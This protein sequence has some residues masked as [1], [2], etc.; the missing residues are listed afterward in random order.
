ML[1]RA[2]EA[3]ATSSRKK[4]AKKT[5]KAPK[6]TAKKKAGKK[7]PKKAGA[8]RYFEFSDGMSHKFWEIRVEGTEVTVH[9]GRIGAA[10]RSLTKSFSD[11]DHAEDHAKK[12]IDQKTSK[13]YVEL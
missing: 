13:G 11:S 8:V 5:K 1:R 12:L 9:Y 4:T 7:R 10:G 6:K 3:R 2:E